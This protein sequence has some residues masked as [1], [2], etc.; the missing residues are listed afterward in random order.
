[1]S[2]AKECKDCVGREA[3]QRC[4]ADP[5]ADSPRPEAAVVA[6]VVELELAPYHS[7]QGEDAPGRDAV[8]AS[9]NQYIRK[10]RQSVH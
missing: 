3:G 5:E 6:V 1:M 2:P 7:D 10:V 4:E 8:P 9:D